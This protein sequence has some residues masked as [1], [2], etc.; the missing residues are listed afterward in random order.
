MNHL[1]Q[2]RVDLPHQT[3]TLRWHQVIEPI[4]PARRPGIALL[5][6]ASDEGIR[7]NGG[8]IGAAQGPASLRSSLANLPLVHSAP[9]YDA[10]DV[11]CVDGNLEGAQ[12]EYA[13]RLANL[14]DDG[15]FPLGLGGGHEIGFATYLGL[16]THLRGRR[17]RVAIVNFDAHFDLRRQAKASSG[18]PF[19]QALD[20]AAY[21]GM[22][23]RY[24]CV[25]VSE[26]AN[27]PHLFAT[28]RAFGVR[29]LRDDELASWTVGT[30]CDR[31]TTW[32]AE[33]DLI[34]LSLCLDV[35][36]QAVAP[37]VSAP[38]ARGVAPEVLEALIDAVMSTGKTAVVDVAELSPA[39]DRDEATARVAA[40][41]LHRITVALG[42][43]A[44][45]VDSLGTAGRDSLRAGSRATARWTSEASR[46]M[47]S[48]AAHDT[49]DS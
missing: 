10:G 46:V 33:V 21:H 43:V 9:L 1:W 3:D 13:R 40:R 16:I 31:L 35:L 28:A 49:V 24:F 23:V 32:L 45:R 27:T 22:D 5:G 26:S 34:Y 4:K 39:H 38:S 11:S 18:T 30:A 42:R 44:S 12:G 14:L 37:G 6:F 17:E 47:S 7:R 29:Y 8:R 19:L 36:P 41:L 48:L 20:H 2:G 15:H 25:G